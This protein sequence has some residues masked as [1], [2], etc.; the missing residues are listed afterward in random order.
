[1]NLED[2]LSQTQKLITDREIK[3]KNIK[4]DLSKLKDKEYEIIL[5]IN[6]ENSIKYIKEFISEFG[7]ILDKNLHEKLRLN[8]IKI[9]YK[10]RYYIESYDKV[11]HT[12]LSKLN[13]KYEYLNKIKNKDIQVKIEIN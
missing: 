7:N 1:M 9:L 11:L 2:E 8:L 3:I 13:I 4:N 6:N 10:D 12:M 5:Q